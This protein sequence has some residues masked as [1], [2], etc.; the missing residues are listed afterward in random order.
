MTGVK[1]AMSERLRKLTEQ[2]RYLGEIDPTKFGAFEGLVTMAIEDAQADEQAE[3]NAA[4]RPQLDDR[5]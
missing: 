3:I 5:R 1:T 2:L 4:A